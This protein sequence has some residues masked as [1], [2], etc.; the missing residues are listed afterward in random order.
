MPDS[1]PPSGSMEWDGAGHGAATRILFPVPNAPRKQRLLVIDDNPTNLKVAVSHL[2]AYSLEVL[3]ARDGES[4]VKRAQLAKP[5]LILL[6]VQM[7]GID[8]YETCRRLK[9]GPE[10]AD[11]PVI[12]MTAMTA[13]QD[14]LRGFEVGAV[15]YVTKPFEASELLARVRAHLQIRALQDRLEDRALDLEVRVAERTNEL[16]RELDAKERH[17]RER[18]QLLEMGRLQS[19]QLRA[20]TRSLLEE[21]GSKDSHL[22]HTL[23][24]RVTERL[25]L[26]RGQ[27]EQAQAASEAMS[28]ATAQALESALAQAVE[29]LEPVTRLVGEL[30]DGL[31]APGAPKV[32]PEPLLVLSSRETE[33]LQLLVAGRSNKEIAYTLDVARTT[34]S[35]YRMRIME[36]L[37]VQDMASLIR[38]AMQAGLAQKPLPGGAE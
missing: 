31:R 3:T 13:T 4:G 9:A 35:T 37:D 20:L 8:G 23:N 7:P 10:T 21:K 5:D 12:F 30:G 18:E 25:E 33:V 34:V 26:V 15:D 32:D 22:A 36:K 29:L 24:A 38:I 11:C 14:K 16:Q 1:A 27:I 6:D 19:E 28:G 17:E 2:E